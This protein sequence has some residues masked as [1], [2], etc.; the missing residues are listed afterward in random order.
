MLSGN[1]VS[2]KTIISK[3]YDDLDIRDVDVPIDKIINWSIEALGFI[4]VIYQNI[5]KVIGDNVDNNPPLRIIDYKCKLPCDFISL[6]QLAIGAKKFG[7][8]YIGSVNTNSFGLSNTVIPNKWGV[9]RFLRTETDGSIIL[10][11]YPD[12]VDLYETSTDSLGNTV[13]TEKTI[14]I[15]SDIN[16]PFN[17]KF[18]INQGYI[19]TSIRTG[20]IVLSYLGMPIDNE[21]LPLIPDTED[22]K[23]AIFWYNVTKYLYPLYLKNKISENKY[24]DAK[25]SWGAARKRAYGNSIMPDTHELEVIKN[26]WLRL[27]PTINEFR[28]SFDSL[29][30]RQN[31][32][33]RYF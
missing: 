20:Y 32:K 26:N 4:G 7:T 12:E 5:N 9:Q 10:Y 16:T 18:E 17:N 11:K 27:L 28:N 21:G 13:K 3:F 25:V 2:I 15:S 6:N 19:H 24:I 22:Y 1:T 30:A 14:K 31:L 23:D 33:N 8:F 29:G